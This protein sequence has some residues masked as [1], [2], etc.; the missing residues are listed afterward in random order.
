MENEYDA[1]VHFLR[2]FDTFCT[3]RGLVWTLHGDFLRH[4]FSGIDTSNT[5]MSFSLTSSNYRM[6]AMSPSTITEKINDVIKTMEMIGLVKKKTH[7]INTSMICDINI[8]TTDGTSTTFSVLLHQDEF[9]KS[10]KT[11]S[12]DSI[13]L[14]SVGLIVTRDPVIDYFNNSSGVALM[15]RLF[16]LRMKQTRPIKTYLNDPDDRKTRLDNSIIMYK[17]SSLIKEGFSF[18]GDH[19]HIVD[20][21]MRENNDCCKHIC[22]I[23]FEARP[24]TRLECTHA[25]CLDCLAMHM[26]RR[27]P[28]HGK[29]PLCRRS[30]SLL[31]VN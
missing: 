11:F 19:L 20:S 31:V 27:G 16:D 9:A 12:C 25:F 14:T 1:R 29:C 17:E 6:V 15:Q 5:P 26:Q 4:F 13:G 22:P 23:C 18:K 21:D 30:I 2:I 8:I 7:I 10:D 3:Q 28:N 24:M